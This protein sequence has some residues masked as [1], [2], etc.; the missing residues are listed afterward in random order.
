[1]LKKTNC[2]DLAYTKNFDI[3]SSP[4][5]E[6]NGAFRAT[7]KDAGVAFCVREEN[8]SVSFRSRSERFS[9]LTERF[10]S[11]TELLAQKK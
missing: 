5:R 7:E 11:K 2:T 6:K 9:K 3:F 4:T 1:M 10:S 8:L